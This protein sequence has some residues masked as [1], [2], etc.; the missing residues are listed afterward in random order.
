[1]I[2]ISFA[3]RSCGAREDMLE[4]LIK[5]IHFQ[6]GISQ[7]E[8]LVCGWT[9][10]DQKALDFRLIEAKDDALNFRGAKMGNT[11]V[12]EAKYE[13]SCLL[14]DDMEM[15]PGWWEII[16]TLPDD[17]DLT[18]FRI[19]DPKR[20][21]WFDWADWKPCSIS[22]MLPPRLKPW[23]EPADEWTYI[24]SGCILVRTEVA[25]EIKWP[26]DFGQRS[27]FPFSNKAFR[28]GYRLKVY[29][30]AE[31]AVILHFMDLRGRHKCRP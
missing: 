10:L 9:E 24:G 21:R 28:S 30:Q 23:N 14:D 25:R 26:E 18:T 13:V 16:Q 4:G 5:S 27:D 12:R 6:Q 19:I 11:L 22:K 2:R 29:P 8:I 20:G 3:I 15:Q 17:W 31:K 7:Y 1:M